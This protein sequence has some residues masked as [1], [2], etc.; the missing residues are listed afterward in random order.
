MTE[1]FLNA[2]IAVSCLDMSRVRVSE[3]ELG[4]LLT[5]TLMDANQP[6]TRGIV[7]RNAFPAQKL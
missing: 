4:S 3:D 6:E 2:Y 7:S 1:N 5:R